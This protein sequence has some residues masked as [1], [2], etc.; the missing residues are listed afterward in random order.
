MYSIWN[1]CHKLFTVFNL[2][3]WSLICGQSVVMNETY[4]K[5]G[6]TSSPIFNL[7]LCHKHKIHSFTW[8]ETYADNY[9][10]KLQILCEL[11]MC[12]S[13]NKCMRDLFAH[14]WFP[15]CFLYGENDDI[16]SW[17]AGTFTGLSLRDYKFEKKAESD[18]KPVEVSLWAQ[19]GSPSA[20]CTC[21]EQSDIAGRVSF[22]LFFARKRA[23][24]LSEYTS[25]YKCLN[26]ASNS[27]LYNALQLRS[28][29]VRASCCCSGSLWAAWV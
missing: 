1:D 10:Y 5:P 25:H 12:I 15:R 23:L 6:C 4:V 13:T 2:L 22:C 24:Y 3:L 29:L 16:I 11:F 28:V 18:D 14:L 17:D 9:K 20:V 21:R 26:P 19:R 8:I 27:G 7:D